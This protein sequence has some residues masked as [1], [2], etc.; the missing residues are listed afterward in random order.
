MMSLDIYSGL[1]QRHQAGLSY[2]A[3]RRAGLEPK[4]DREV[5]AALLS[6]LTPEDFAWVGIAPPS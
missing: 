4:R 1:P 3:Q 6:N 2:R 5:T